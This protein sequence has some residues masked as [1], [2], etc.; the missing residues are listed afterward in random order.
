MV[1]HGEWFKSSLSQDGGGCV[2]ARFTQEGVEVRDSKNPGGP[3]LGFTNS[4]WDAFLGGVAL[5]EFT[6]A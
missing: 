6:G 4:E 1:Q 2:E 5:G 3:K